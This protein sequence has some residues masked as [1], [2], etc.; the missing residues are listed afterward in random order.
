MLP[1]SHSPTSSCTTILVSMQSRSVHPTMVHQEAAIPASSTSVIFVCRTG[2]V[3][4]SAMWLV[5]SSAQLLLLALAWRSS[6]S[7]SSTLSMA[8]PLVSTCATMCHL[9]DSTALVRLGRRIADRQLDHYIVSHKD[10][11][12]LH[13]ESAI[14][15]FTSLEPI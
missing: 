4:L 8:L 13:C 5:Q 1:T 14:L 12:L 9:L 7:I 2:L 15:P 3:L 11:P 6:V 10:E